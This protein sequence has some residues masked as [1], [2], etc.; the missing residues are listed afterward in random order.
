MNI[1]FTFGMA[2]RAVLAIAITVS[3]FVACDEAEQVAQ[4]SSSQGI[5]GMVT[6]TPGQNYEIVDI[7]R[8]EPEP[9]PL[10][11][12]TVYLIRREK[13]EGVPRF[14]DSTYTDSTG[15]YILPSLPG[16]YYVAVATDNI[17]A[18]ILVSLPG[19][20][21]QL[22]RRIHAIVGLN[23]LEGRFIEQPFNVVEL[24]TQ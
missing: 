24:S 5:R 14:V 8:T 11:S 6:L 3:L 12:A 22:R 7:D 17:A 23:V 2:F 18:P 15:R 21:T 9:Q 19:D 20:T 13:S 10:D 1:H 4:R 16:E